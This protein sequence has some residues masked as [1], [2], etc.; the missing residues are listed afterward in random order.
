MPAQ[1]QFALEYLRSGGW[2][3]IP[4]GICSV[5]MWMFI[6]ERIQAYRVLGSGDVTIPEAVGAVSGGAALRPVDGLRAR[7][8]RDFLAERCGYPDID[9]EIVRHS[10]MKLRN[11][12]RARLAAIAVLAAVAPLLGLL[13]TVLGMIATF[14]VIAFFG[15]SNAKAMA[16]G[17]SV[18]LITTQSGLIVAIPGLYISGNLSRK[19]KHLEIMLDEITTVLVRHVRGQTAFSREAGSS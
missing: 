14:D 8:V 3:M 6:V 1:L 10:A 18:A 7:L 5:A 19:A 15:T 4:I 17:I 9:G 11:A 12:L 16:G 13:G 2:V